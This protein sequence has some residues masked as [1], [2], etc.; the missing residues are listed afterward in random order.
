MYSAS[1]NKTPVP[2]STHVEAGCQPIAVSSPTSVRSPLLRQRRVMCFE[3]ELSDD[4]DSDNTGNTGHFHRPTKSDS[5][6]FSDAQAAQISKTDSAVVIA[7]S[8]TS[9]LDVDGDSEDG[10]D[11]HLCG[12]SDVTTPLNGSFSQCE[13]SITTKSE[14][15]GSESPFMPIRCPFDYRAGVASSLGSVSGNLTIISENYTNQDDGQVESKRSP[16]LEHKAV[17]RVKSMMSIEAP[18][19]PQQLKSKVD[20]PSPC[21]ALSQ[22]PSQPTQ[23]GRNPRTAGGSVPHQH[24]KKGDASELEGVCAID[25]VTLKRSED[26]S[27]GL[28]LE[29]MSSPLKVVITGLKPGGAA[30]RV[31]LIDFIFIPVQY[32]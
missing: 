6:N 24:C 27:F 12:S 32:H 13:E 23:C 17:T 15:P 14:S 11:L 9:S 5:L 28:D 31:S 20:E 26:E 25:S 1:Q 7:T 21:L 8:A 30:E 4:E 29:I 3:D 19:L 22:P 18:N 10:G 2:L 16:K